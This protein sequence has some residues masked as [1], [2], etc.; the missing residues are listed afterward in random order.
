MKYYIWF[1]YLSNLISRNSTNCDL[2]DKSRNGSEAFHEVYNFPILRNVKLNYC[3][4]S[5]AA[6]PGT[7]ARD[8]TEL[9]SVCHW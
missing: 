7:V 5:I 1:L 9:I 3:S 4:Y 8:L 6:I 2:S